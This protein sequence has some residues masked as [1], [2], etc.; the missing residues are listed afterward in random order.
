MKRHSHS[1]VVLPSLQPVLYPS[2]FT[3]R[4]KSFCVLPKHPTLET[5]QR[6]FTLAATAALALASLPK[7]TP[8][9]RLP[10]IAEQFLPRTHYYLERRPVKLH[11]RFAHMSPTLSR[12]PCIDFISALLTGEPFIDDVLSHNVQRCTERLQVI[13]AVQEED[14]QCSVC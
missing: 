11:S 3:P 5:H 6:S 9:K 14:E 1:K 13:P 2:S 12:I 8:R 7:P 10:P 4:T